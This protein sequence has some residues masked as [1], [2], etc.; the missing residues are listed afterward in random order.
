[1]VGCLV[2]LS[3]NGIQIAT[4]LQLSSL[5]TPTRVKHVRVKSKTDTTT[6]LKWR[7]QRSAD[8]YQIR[9]TKPNGKVLKKIWT[10][11]HN[12][13]VTGLTSGKR[14]GFKVRAEIGKKSRHNFGRYSTIVRARTEVT[15]TTDD[16]TEPID[17]SEDDT[18]DDT[19]DTTDQP[20]DS[21]DDTT[22]TT[23]DTDVDETPDDTDDDSDQTDEVDETNDTGDDTDESTNDGVDPEPAT[24]VLFGFWGLNGYHT[25][26]GL[27]DVQE[28][29]RATVFQVAQSGVNYTVN[30]FLPMVEASGM[31]VTLRLSGSQSQYTTAGSFDLAKWKA[32]IDRWRVSDTQPHDIQPYI[33]NGTLV[34]HMILDDIDTYAVTDATAADLDEM[35]RYSEEVFPGLMTYVR[36]KCSR[37]PTPTVNDG[38]YVELDNCVNQY[39]NYQGF[40]DGPVADYIVTQTAAAEALGLG[41]INGMNIADGGDGSSGQP[42]WSSGKYAM[43]AEEITEYGEALLAVPTIQMF[44]MW[45]YDGQEAWSD[46]SIGS[47]YFD[48]PELQAALA[49]LGEL[50]AQ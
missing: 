24:P 5:N 45:E 41:M 15:E 39:T 23:D 25:A 11:K 36:Q 34:G 19:T 27:A 18:V 30:T 40:S 46:G 44:L 12:K 31:N 49:G 8:R 16:S 43:S 9:V 10:R 42:G 1:M 26:A 33:D 37:V 29:Y 22:D 20:D 48:Q 6:T 3:F 17:N 14:Y 4:A 28:R 2:V 35:A 47:D 38:Q 32:L 7:D 21:T 13:M 50:A